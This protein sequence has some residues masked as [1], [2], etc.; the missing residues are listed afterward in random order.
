MS[1]DA[2]I[3]ENRGLVFP[4]RVRITGSSPR[5]AALGRAADQDYKTL[6]TPGLSATVEIKTG[7]RSVLSFLLSPIARS[8][9]EAGR[10]R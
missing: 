6:L 9:S 10:E 3:D 7:T 2:M 5:Q 4:A 1:A 8:A